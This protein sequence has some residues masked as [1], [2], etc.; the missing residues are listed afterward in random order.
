[1]GI[2]RAVFIFIATCVICHLAPSSAAFASEELV[3]TETKLEQASPPKLTKSENN[4][5]NVNKNKPRT[6]AKKKKEEKITLFAKPIKI[7][8]YA[9]R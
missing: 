9:N 5:S 1:M 3:V 7:K 4:I 2:N 8:D 6:N